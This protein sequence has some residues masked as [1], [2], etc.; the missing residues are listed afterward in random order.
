VE[1][2]VCGPEASDD[3]VHARYPFARFLEQKDALVPE[4]WREG[5]DAAGGEIVALTVSQ[6]IPARDWIE[7]IRLLQEE[8]DVVGG[9]IDPG[10]GLRFVD[11]AEYFCRYAR[12]LRPFEGRETLDLPGDNAAYKHEVLEGVRDVYRHGFWEPF[13]HAR[14]AAGGV[15]CWQSP[16]LVVYQGRSAGWRAFTAQRLAHGRQYGRDRGTSLSAPRTVVGV[17]AAPVVPPLMTWRVLRLV[18]GKRRYRLRA[19]ACLPAILWFNVAWA[20]GEVRGYLDLLR[21]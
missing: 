20:A 7:R 17:V 3:I 15:V 11:W 9:A 16:E 10:E 5:I 12:D 19:L 21:R 18:V 1:V 8:Y 13:V 14:L 6:M 4:L 2:L